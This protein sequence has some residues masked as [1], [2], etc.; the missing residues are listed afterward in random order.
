MTH[1]TETLGQLAIGVLERQ[2]AVFQGHAS[3]ARAGDQV[4]DVHQCRVAT[5]R[6][7]AALRL[8]DDVLP[9]S[10]ASRLN[11]DLKW[12]AAHLGQVRDLDVQLERLEQSGKQLELVSALQPYAHWLSEQRRIAKGGLN[13]ALDAP[14]FRDITETFGGLSTWTPNARNDGPAIEQAP[15]RLT[16][17]NRSLDK[18]ARRL[19]RDSPAAD[20]HEV[21]IFGKR[22]RYAAEF[23]VP[24]YGKAAERLVSSLT[25]LQDLL[26]ALQDGV[27]SAER[28]HAAVVEGG[29][30]WPPETLLAL[31][32]LIQYDRQRGEQI[33]GEFREAYEGVVGKAWKELEANVV[34]S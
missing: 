9:R 34:M 22:L 15:R 33:R 17:A 7:R 18:R 24:L 2:S 20:F 12:I 16:R 19:T 31:G 27:V 3:G 8:F 14:R 28:V 26:G 25:D 32:Q 21:R 10:A 29:A 4:R 23:F 5:R 11:A 1:T 30:T 13:E 6:M